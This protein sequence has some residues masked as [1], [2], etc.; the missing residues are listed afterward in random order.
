MSDY[1]QF[2]KEREQID[3]LF[4]KGFKITNITE[5]LSGAF[6]D[7]EKGE[8]KETVHVTTAEARKYFSARLILQQKEIV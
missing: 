3:F 2:Q 1:Q 5:N 6:V 7:F 4:G 8:S